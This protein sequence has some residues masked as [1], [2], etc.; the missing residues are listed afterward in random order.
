MATATRQQLLPPPNETEHSFSRVTREGKKIT[1]N[2]KVIQQPE[3]ARACGAGAKSSADRRPVDPPPV[4]ELHIYESE[5]NNDLHRTDITFAYNANFFLFATLDVARPIAQGRTTGQPP[6]CP[7]LTGCPVAGIAYLDRPAQ[8]GYFIFP[9][10]SVRH[11]GRYRL[12][13]NLYEEIKDAKDSDK[14]S[15]LPPETLTTTTKPSKPTAPKVFL[16][17]RLEVKSIPF[18]VYSAKKFPGLATST[19]LSRV[20]AE[21]GCRVRIRR[22]V[23]MRRRGDKGNKESY[24]FDDD[25]YVPSPRYQTPDTYVPTPIE[26]PRSTSNSTVDAPFGYGPEAQRRPSVPDYGFPCPPSQQFHQIAGPAAPPPPG[27][28]SHLSFSSAQS[29]YQTPHFPTPPTPTSQP[30]AQSEPPQSPLL[31]TRNASNGTDYDSSASQSYSYP[32]VRSKRGDEYPKTSLPPLRIE[33]P[34]LYTEP[35]NA[36]QSAMQPPIRARTP[37]SV[38]PSLPPLKT[39]SGEYGQSLPANSYDT[40]SA[41]R[42]YDTDSTLTKRSHE[43][44]F[45]HQERP[46][47]NG[48]RPETEDPVDSHRGKNRWDRFLV[49]IESSMEYRRADGSMSSKRV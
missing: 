7:V 36:Y 44:T 11:E 43:E 27:Y 33:H 2:L 3:R 12:N 23:R 35:P 16:H 47:Q 31:H 15:P 34:Q 41:R 1:Y 8:A 13:F 48:M 25:P 45:G 14:D 18:M 28:P 29:Q 42:L 37:A 22:D 49:G 40:G 10:L 26:R 38:M 6:T 4:V 24:D 20:V 39:L 30:V 17:F 5:P 46:L 21:Q 32:H 9:D 19:S